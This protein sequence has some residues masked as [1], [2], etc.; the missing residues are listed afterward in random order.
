MTKREIVQ[1]N[2]SLAIHNIRTAYT[3]EGLIEA[4]S[5]CQD[6]MGVNTTEAYSRVKMLCADIKTG[7]SGR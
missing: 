4:M 2:E 7:E 6:Y 3:N 5:L 1:H